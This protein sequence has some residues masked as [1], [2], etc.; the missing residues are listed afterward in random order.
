MK[1]QQTYGVAA[2]RSDS[3][4]RAATT[5]QLCFSL[6]MA[7]TRPVSQP[8]N[9][10]EICSSRIHGPPNLISLWT[11]LPSLH[12][13]ANL[14]QLYSPELLPTFKWTIPSLSRRVLLVIKAN[15]QLESPNLYDHVRA[16]NPPVW[17][18]TTIWKNEP[19]TGA[20]ENSV[21]TTSTLC[22]NGCTGPPSISAIV[23][24]AVVRT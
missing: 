21:D 12:T 5:T 6:R 13:Q 16:D 4:F 22:K 20:V 2:T 3:A 11:N 15:T 1:E 7:C 23:D 17:S 24:A 9:R 19:R 14:M 18:C 10:L 8:H